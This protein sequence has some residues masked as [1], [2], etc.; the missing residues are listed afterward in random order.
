MDLL[1][2]VRVL[3]LTIGTPPPLLFPT[4]CVVVV[5]S[6]IIQLSTFHLAYIKHFV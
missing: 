3:S 5:V 4:Q 2:E 6:I 1:A